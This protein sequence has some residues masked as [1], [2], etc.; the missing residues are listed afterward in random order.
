MFAHIGA[1]VAGAREAVLLAERIGGVLDHAH[2]AQMLRDLDPLRETGGF[3]TTP[4][5]ADVRAD[6]VLRIGAAAAP[7]L[8]RPA[9]PHGESVARR[10]VD[11][12]AP[13]SE[14]ETLATLRWLIKRP[15][16]ARDFPALSPSVE[17]LRGARFGVAIWDAA[18]LPDL[19]VE[20]IHGLVRDLNETTRFSTLATSAPDNGAGVQSVC[21]WMTGF[22]PRTGFARGGPQHD[23]W[24]F[25]ARR[26]MRAGESDCVIWISALPGAA[27]PP[28][29]VDIWLDVG[30][31]ADAP[32]A[33]IRIPVSA[34]GAG[35]VVFDPRVGALTASPAGVSG[36]A[37]TAAAALRLIREK[38]PC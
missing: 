17:A 8:D 37:P 21:G 26:L 25:D 29:S 34:P 31:D 12:A 3:T 23:P 14:L 10:V 6:V 30:V 19:A 1:D 28:E 24:R 18:N 27:P 15:D 38:L 4:L 13:G 9:R 20:M 22:P 7:W 35:D 32:A 16:L 5:E 2:S 11:V 36:R 33:R